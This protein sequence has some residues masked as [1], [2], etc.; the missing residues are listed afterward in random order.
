MRFA[1]KLWS[2]DSCSMPMSAYSSHAFGKFEG[3]RY[4]HLTGVSPLAPSPFLLNTLPRSS[5]VLASPQ[6]HVGSVH[7]C[8]QNL[9]MNHVQSQMLF[10]DMC[11]HKSTCFPLSLLLLLLTSHMC[12]CQIHIQCCWNATC[13]GQ[14]P[15]ICCSNSHIQSLNHHCWLPNVAWIH[16]QN[17]TNIVLVGGAITILKNR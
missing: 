15:R 4:P 9:W 7:S 17:Y 13:A 10:M 14:C 8:A 2:A 3:Q 1:A 11:L 5:T 6:I 16:H 12:W